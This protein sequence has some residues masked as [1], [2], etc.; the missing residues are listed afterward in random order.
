MQ[1]DKL[2]RLHGGGQHQMDLLI[3][4]AVADSPRFRRRW[5]E[6]RRAVAGVSTSTRLLLRDSSTAAGEL[7][8]GIDGGESDSD[9]PGEAAQLFVG[10]HAIGVDG[11]D[12]DR[13]P[14]GQALA[15]R[16]FDQRSGFARAGG[17]G[18]DDRALARIPA[19]PVA[20]GGAKRR[21]FEMASA[22]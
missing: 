16:D 9:D 20:T 11:K 2:S 17:T 1:R 10:G 7:L 14:I 13:Q 15:N 12:A 21:R 3:G 8:H 19:W 4:H 5:S 6:F 22:A 18:E